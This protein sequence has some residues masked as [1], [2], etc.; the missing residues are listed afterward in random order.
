MRPL[1][2]AHTGIDLSVP[3]YQEIRGKMMSGHVEYNIVVVT[4]MAAF[5]LAK[6][7]PEDIIQFMVSKKYSEIE[8]FYQKLVTHYPQTS[9]PPL[10]RKVLFVGEFDIRERRAAFN[11]IMRCISKDTDLATCPELMEFLGTRSTSII[12]VKGKNL[13]DEEGSDE[14]EAFDF[15]KEERMSDLIPQFQS[16]KKQD[17][18]VEKEKEE[19]EEED[20]V[21]PLG[22][23]KSKRT[24]KPTPPPVKDDKPK[25]TIFDE[26]ADPDEGLFGSAKDSSFDGNKRILA[27][28]ENLKLFEDPD[29][30]GVVTIGDSLLLPTACASR[31]HA[32]SASLEEDTEELLRVEEDFEK[33]WTLSSQ[34]KPKVPPKPT[35]PKKPAVTDPKL[36]LS[37]V[38]RV[39]LTEVKVQT[40]GEVDIL[41]YIQENES[42]SSE[43]PSLF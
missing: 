19:E 38:Q 41:Q 29:L 40:M 8:E 35:V 42:I 11:E 13:P 37:S 31:E 7:K 26:E 4:Q 27:A 14:N 36:P 9:L 6:H 32:L 1:Q 21:D 20:D 2:N 25:L 23:I 15:F 18:E 39:K 3:E 34:P 24:K 5:K 17:V 22:V 28:K 33:M 10:P 43:E 16:L 12:E 30:G